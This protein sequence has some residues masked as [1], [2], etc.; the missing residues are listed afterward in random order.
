M[1]YHDYNSESH[2]HIGSDVYADWYTLEKRGAK[3]FWVMSGMEA[4]KLSKYYDGTKTP[5]SYEAS[6]ALGKNINR[7]WFNSPLDLENNGGML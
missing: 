2:I 1:V 7:E 4:Y 5:V 3:S 6:I